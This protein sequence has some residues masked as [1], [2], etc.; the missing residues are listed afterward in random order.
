MSEV[1][2]KPYLLRALFE[3]CCDCGF[4]PYI[5]VSVDAN[6]QVPREFVK[7]GE[8]VLNL[9]PSATNK[10]EIGNAYVSFQ[11]R[12]GGVARELFIPVGNV[13]SI[14]ARENGH[15]MAFD[16]TTAEGQQGQDDA[17]DG[18]SVATAAP[19]RPSLTSVQGSKVD[20]S[21]ASDPDEPEEPR[22]PPPATVTP[23]GSRTRLKR[24]K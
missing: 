1:S 8:I 10:L 6:T 16:V 20:S 24:V 18:A 21:G 19:G 9:S 15:G 4:T 22:D 12:F 17:P 3:W 23:I 11:A 14:Y 2:T 7:N 5:T 13:I